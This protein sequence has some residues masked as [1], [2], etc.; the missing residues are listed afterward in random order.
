MYSLFE[1]MSERDVAEACKPLHKEKAAAGTI[2]MEEKG[3]VQALYIIKSG[4]IEIRKRIG[5]RQEKLGTLSAG[6]FFGEMAMVDGVRNSATVVTTRDSILLKIDRETL[7][8]LIKQFPVISWNIARTLYSRLQASADALKT[9][10]ET[11]GQKTDKE[12]SRLH[13]LIEATQT[14]NT[15]LEI[16][17]VLELILN[18]AMRITDAE[19][20]TIYLIDENTH[21]IWSRILVG[22]EMNE[23]RQSI[24]KGISGYVAQTGETVNIEDAY[25]DPRFNPEFDLKSGFKTKNILCMP[26]NNRDNKIIGVFQLINKRIGKFDTEDETFLRAFSINASIAI[27]NSRLAAEM[28]KSERLSAVGQMAATIIHDIKNPM[29]TI[30]LYAQV[31]RKKAGNEEASGL[32]DEIDK[33]IDRLVNMAQEVLDFSRGVSQLNFQKVAYGDFLQEVLVFLQ[34]DFEKRNISLLN[35]NSFESEIEIDADKITRML[36]NI[37]GNSADAMPDGGKFFVRSRQSGTSLMI[38]L[39]DTGTGMPEEIRRRIFEPFV[40][41]GKKHGTGLGMSIVKKIVDDHGGEIQIQSELG[42][43]TKMT[44]KL[45]LIQSRA[46]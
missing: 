46:K 21:E 30:R 44:V 26:M 16:T 38:E 34:R 13:A 39:E 8:D 33:Q 5:D 35:E 11:Q 12:I 25:H 20:G 32:V 10:M 37:A 6:D 41:Y 15:S 24:G 19:R 18:E 2:I 17:R 1:G 43:G 9:Q 7:P 4:E 36:M 22:N 40:T 14:V 45:P 31:L 23:I 3:P 29:A 42:K 28:V 27:E